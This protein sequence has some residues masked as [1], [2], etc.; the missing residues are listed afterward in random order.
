MW[1]ITIHVIT[2][3]RKPK[4][5]PLAPGALPPSPPLPP[6]HEKFTGSAEPAEPPIRSPL[7]PRLH[8]LCERPSPSPT[9]PESGTLPS[10]FPPSRVGRGPPTD[11]NRSGPR[12][13]NRSQTAHQIGPSRQTT[14]L[15]IPPHTAPPRHHPVLHRHRRVPRSP[16]IVPSSCCCYC[17]LLHPPPTVRI[18]D[19][20]R[21]HTS[22]RR[23]CACPSSEQARRH[24][25]R[26]SVRERH[27]S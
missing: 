4:Y 12:A 3:F 16:M 14:H 1:E 26:G 27:Y 24:T 23:L 10:S 2:A 5:P 11:H 25:M 13:T 21:I 6:Q 7:H 18:I 22:R 8:H 17:L 19:F 9:D 20:F 15:L